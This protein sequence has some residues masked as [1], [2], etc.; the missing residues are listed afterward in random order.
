[1]SQVLL[2]SLTAMANPSLVAAVTVMLLL[3]NPKPL[4]LG[5]LLGALM[6]SVTLGLV[7]VFAAQH[8]SFTQTAK[9]TVNPVVDL[10][11]GAILLCLAFVLHA[12]RDRRLRERRAER[13]RRKQEGK[14]SEPPRWQRELGRGDPKIT[15]AVG[16]VLS[17]PGASYLAALGSIVKLHTADAVAVLLVVMVNV[18]MLALLEVPL[19]GYFVAPEK[20]PLAVNRAKAR[21]ARDGRMAIVIGATVVGSLL[22]ARGVITSLT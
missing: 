4:M 5:Y 16:A 13:K 22:I 18:I 12:G 7:I 1:M 8:W 20:T 3:P 17:L 10:V 6:T 15:F 2:F 11:L 14:P 9:H 19:I 21:L